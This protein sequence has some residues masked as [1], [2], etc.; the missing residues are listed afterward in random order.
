MDDPQLF[1]RST[2]VAACVHDIGKD[3]QGRADFKQTRCRFFSN[4]KD[5]SGTVR[6]QMDINERVNMALKFSNICGVV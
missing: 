6:T 5:L 2:G 3:I 1:A 4:Y